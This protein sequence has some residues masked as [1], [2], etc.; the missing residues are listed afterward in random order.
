MQ[1]LAKKPKSSIQKKQ[2]VIQK[3]TKKF[4][5]ETRQET[6]QKMRFI[7]EGRKH[8]LGEGRD[9]SQNRRKDGKSASENEKWEIK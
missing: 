4:D 5:L 7:N 2:K 6:H 1:K 3:P 8:R 9:R